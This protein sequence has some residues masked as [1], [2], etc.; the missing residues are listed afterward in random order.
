MIA[1]EDMDGPPVWYEVKL[2]HW[3]VEVEAV[4][5]LDAIDQARKYFQLEWP[6]FYYDIAVKSW[7]DFKVELL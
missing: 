4:S 1:P 7:S 5:Q 3:S 2:G 6:M